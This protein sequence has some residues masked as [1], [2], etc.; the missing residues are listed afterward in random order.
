M[1]LVRQG[2][3]IVAFANILA[4]RAGTELSV[5]LM[6][7][8]PEVRGGVMDFLF[9]ELML[10]GKE[11]GFATFSLGMAPLSGF[12]TRTFMPAWNKLALAVFRYGEQFYNFKGLRKYK[13][14]FDPH[15]EPRYLAAPGGV[16]VPFILRAV[17]T[18][19][20]RGLEGLVAR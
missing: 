18:L 2:G 10:W 14:K 16:R 19:V 9:M 6:R 13:E 15:W 20:S 8:L 1:A 12:E 11:H 7:Y 4:A 5:D 3:E 17:A